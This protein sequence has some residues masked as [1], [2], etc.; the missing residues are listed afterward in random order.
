MM[1]MLLTKPA[2]VARKSPNKTSI[3]Y[4]STM[5]PINAQRMRMSDMPATK[6]RVPFHFCLRAKK[7]TVLV[8]PMISVRPMMKSI[9]SECVRNAQV[10]CE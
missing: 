7:A 9:C 2:M 10:G 8:V 1:G 6:A 4:N 5:K 3:P